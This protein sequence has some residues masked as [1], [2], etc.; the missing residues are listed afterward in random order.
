MARLA[1]FLCVLFVIP[2]PAAAQED[3]TRK[4]LDKDFSVMMSW[5]PGRYDNQEQ[6]YFEEELQIDE[7]LRHERI[8]SIFEPV[9]LAAF[10]D[11]VFYVQQYLDGDP[12][13]IYRQRIYTFRVDYDENA[14]R[15]DIYVPKDPDAIKDAHLD[16]S[17]LQG[18]SPETM[19]EYPGCEV[20]WRRESQQF[21]GYMREE[22]CRIESTRSGR[23]I[24]VTDDLM[25]NAN[26]IW[27]RDTAVDTDGNYVYGHK[28]NEHH[29]LRKARM[30][31]CWA[32]ILRRGA[33][34]QADSYFDPDVQIHDQGGL[35]WITTDETD[36][37]TYG[38]K[39]RNVSWPYGNNRPS[40]V[41]YVYE[42]GNDKAIS[43]SWTE[44][45]AERIG[46]NLR[47]IQSSCTLAENGD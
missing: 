37:Q 21:I 30:F 17:K 26:E 41:L 44:P 20:Y 15:L 13:K 46:I 31:K 1:L 25:L 12:D 19:I 2:T 11:N 24:I 6:V 9:E 10:G 28:G 32:G 5:F 18:L 42:P 34:E 40:L 22:A 8:H 29:K 4:I 38:L 35:V 16:P 14:V 23:T 47:S 3:A 43:Y 33:T 27:I 39:I 36:P 45:G 7:E